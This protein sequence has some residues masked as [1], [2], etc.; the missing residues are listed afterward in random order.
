MNAFDNKGV[1][2]LH[3]GSADTS[4]H[5]CWGDLTFVPQFVA[6]PY[7]LSSLLCRDR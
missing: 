3:A 1:G 6:K 2:R 5:N 4:R 7:M